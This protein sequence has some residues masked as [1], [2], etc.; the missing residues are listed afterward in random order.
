M[1]LLLFLPRRHLL[2][3][4][5]HFLR[6]RDASLTQPFLP[7]RILPAV[8]HSLVKTSKENRVD[9]CVGGA[10]KEEA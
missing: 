10:V 5:V 6:I 4:A 2:H 8:K 7:R 3:Q 1:V 9:A